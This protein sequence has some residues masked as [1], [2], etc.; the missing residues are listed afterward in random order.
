M[1]ER[2]KSVRDNS[3]EVDLTYLVHPVNSRLLAGGL[4]NLSCRVLVGLNKLRNGIIYLSNIC[5]L[6]RR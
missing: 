5:E 3:V 2:S 4:Q 6:S 1:T